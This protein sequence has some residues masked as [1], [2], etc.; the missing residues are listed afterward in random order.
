MLVFGSGQ[1]NDSLRVVEYN[2][3]RD[4]E[5]SENIKK[6]EFR[7]LNVKSVQSAQLLKWSPNDSFL[8]CAFEKLVI[9]GYASGDLFKIG[10]FKDHELE[11]AAITWAPDSTRIATGSLDGKIVIRQM[12]AKSLF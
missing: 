12:D 6:V 1:S 4:Y 8:A 10:D 3:S 9:W 2:I 5:A 11:I 7:A